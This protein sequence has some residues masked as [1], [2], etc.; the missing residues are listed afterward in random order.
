MG[1]FR[2]LGGLYGPPVTEMIPLL[3]QD[4]GPYRVFREV[5]KIIVY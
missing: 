2:Q 1:A 4:N 3:P 5:F